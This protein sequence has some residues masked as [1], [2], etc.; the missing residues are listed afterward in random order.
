MGLRG[1]GRAQNECL[2]DLPSP[3]LGAG[4]LVGT[5]WP[6]VVWPSWSLDLSR[7]GLVAGLTG[8]WRPRGWVLEEWM[9]AGGA[10]WDL[11]GP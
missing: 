11:G 10:E 5:P 8:P 4:I 1:G 2:R 7:E 9:A 3:S 6:L